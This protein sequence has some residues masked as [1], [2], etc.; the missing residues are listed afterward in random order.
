MNIQPAYI[1]D[2]FSSISMEELMQ[3]ED[4]HNILLP[5]EYIKFLLNFNGGLFCNWPACVG[6]PNVSTLGI[7]MLFGINVPYKYADLHHELFLFRIE[8]DDEYPIL[9]IG[10]D[11][12]GNLFCLKCTEK[13]K[14]E[15]Y[16]YDHESGAIE[17]II[18]QSFS[19][20]INNI[21]IYNRDSYET[22]PFFQAIESGD[23][24][25][26]AS[27][28]DQTDFDHNTMSAS[29][30][31]PLGYAAFHLQPRVCSLLLNANFN[32]NEF[33]QDHNA[34]LH[35]TAGVSTTRLLLNAGG[36]I[37]I[38]NRNGETPLLSCLRRGKELAAIFLITRGADCKAHDNDG[39]NYSSY[40]DYCHEVKSFMCRSDMV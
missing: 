16:L 37:E 28:I 17:D 6:D 7:D 18:S 21:Y 27:Y 31:S 22:N 8:I 32:P 1:A 23:L 5:D 20:F 26:I 29:G 10:R 36:N 33:D 14:S 19:S 13:A 35:W 3:F 38:R 39:N 25:S 12:F 9:P 34:P 15:V 2:P 30:H 4:S 24:N 11:P 40:I